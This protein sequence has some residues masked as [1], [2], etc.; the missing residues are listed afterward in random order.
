MKVKKSGQGGEIYLVSS[1]KPGKYYK[2]N[3]EKR[4]CNCPHWVFRLRQKGESCKHILEVEKILHN[5]T[6]DDFDKALQKV[7]DSGEIDSIELIEEFGEGIV[8]ELIERGEISEK[9]G[10][11]QPLA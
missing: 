10:K 4:S 8:N 5:E 11:L 3:Y 1:S 2:V 6:K 9:K 7:K